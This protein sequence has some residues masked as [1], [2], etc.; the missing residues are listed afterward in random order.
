MENEIKLVRED[1]WSVVLSKVKKPNKPT[2]FQFVIKNGEHERKYSI[3]EWLLNNEKLTEAIIIKHF[4]YLFMTE[5]YF[6]YIPGEIMIFP[7]N[8]VGYELSKLFSDSV[9]TLLKSYIESDMVKFKLETDIEY[10][11]TVRI[12]IEGNEND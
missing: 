12:Y 11:D 9:L 5:K 7:G 1:E 10:D 4:H 3:N 8:S 2:L 6:G